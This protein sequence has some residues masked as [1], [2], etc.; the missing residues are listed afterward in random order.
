[1]TDMN[2][3]DNDRIEELLQAEYS[4]AE[5]PREELHAR[6]TRSTRGSRARIPWRVPLQVAA[7]ILI[8]VVGSEYGRAIASEPVHNLQQPIPID[9]QQS[10]SQYVEQ[11][12]VVLASTDHYSEAQLRE[13]RQVAIAILYAA[14]VELQS[15]D[16]DHMALVAALLEASRGEQYLSTN[17][18][19]QS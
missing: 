10:G 8:F 12:S 2:R 11:L 1:M 9:I 13:F 18:D 16:D 15:A 3:H 6:I 4:R 19:P 14:A 7:A 5:L 17:S